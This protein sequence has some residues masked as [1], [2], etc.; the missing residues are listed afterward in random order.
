[1]IIS[2]D[3]SS[4]IPIY[5]QLRNQIVTGIGKGQLK[6]GE[7]LPTVR[8]LARDAGVNTM[9][10]NKT[11]QILKAE[12]FVEIDRRK[13]ATVCSV[14]KQDDIFKEKLEAD[15]E[16]LS[17]EACLKGIDREEFLQ[18]CDRMFSCMNPAGAE[19]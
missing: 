8:Q 7:S 12:G 5:V 9:T 18:I 6:A 15:L 13:G 11:Y 17:A 19:V 16:L 4:S 3:T 2:L 14:Q 1:M 10:V